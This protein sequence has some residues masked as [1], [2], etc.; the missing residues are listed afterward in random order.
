MLTDELVLLLQVPFYHELA[1]IAI[2]HSGYGVE[3]LVNLFFMFGLA[4]ILVGVVFYCLGKFELG[5]IVYFFP[6]HVLVG[7]I[8]GIGLY[9]ARTGLEVTMDL[10]FSVD[11]ILEHWNLLRVTFL[12]EILLRILERITLD[13]NGKPRFSLLSPIYFCSITPIFYLGLL[14]LG[15]PIES[16][17]GDGYFFPAIST[18]TSGNNATNS[19]G[20]WES[21]LQDEGIL[22]M[23]RILDVRVI[24]WGAL[25][26]SIPTMVALT[27][28]SNA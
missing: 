2:K 19:S 24:S 27:L 15:V 9:I 12:F 4:S 11:N 1:A 8:G 3:S 21:V 6:T 23:W 17:R 18:A 22:D 28:V 7:C 14:I 5:R 13:E 20:L 16:A 10:A 25:F 26:E